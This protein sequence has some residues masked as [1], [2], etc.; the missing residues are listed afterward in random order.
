MRQDIHAAHCQVQLARIAA[1][2][3]ALV[4]SSLP[5]LHSFKRGRLLARSLRIVAARRAGAGNSDLV[6]LARLNVML[7]LI[8]H[9]VAQAKLGLLDG[10][11]H[12]A[13]LEEA[14]LVG[15]DLAGAIRIIIILQKL[16]L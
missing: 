2:T 13:A 3:T 14:L 1:F 10:P 8:E 5:R 12:N 6:E 7:A 4:S 9:V 16:V 15:V 11:E